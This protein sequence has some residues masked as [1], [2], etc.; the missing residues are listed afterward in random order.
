MAV[1]TRPFGNT[2]VPF[3]DAYRLR[4]VAGSKG[5]RV[6][7]AVYHLGC[8]LAYKIVGRVAVVAHCD[9]SVA[10]LHPAVVLLIHNVA[11]LAGKR[12]IG[13]VRCATG[14]D[15]GKGAYSNCNSYQYPNDDRYRRIRMHVR[16]TIRAK[17]HF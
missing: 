1:A 4:E 10:G 6:E 11:V 14:V 17:L 9:I 3:G 16:A 2:T 7:E 13:K 8:V 12:V 5:I 15:K